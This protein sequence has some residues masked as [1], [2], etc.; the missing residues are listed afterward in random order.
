MSSFCL[1]LVAGAVHTLA[2]LNGHGTAGETAP[3]PISAA[4]IYQTEDSVILPMDAL[5]ATEKVAPEDIRRTLGY[6]EK[7]K[8]GEMKKRES[9][10]VVERGDETYSIIDGNRSYMALKQLGAKNVPAI[11]F[12][13]PFH[14]DVKTFDELI[15]LQTEAVSEFH[16]FVTSLGEAHR[17]EVSEHSDPGNAEAIHRKARE[18]YGEDYAKVVDILSADISLAA[19]ALQKAVAELFDR[20]SIM[21]VYAHEEDGGS[22]AYIRLS[23]GALAEI[24]LN[25][26]PCCHQGGA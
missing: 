18:N 10:S 2:F 23:N 11:V 19:E 13:R 25:E 6:I 24:R 4:D 12:S 1:L 26:A 3:D 14:K 20:D 5:R 15:A 16:Q 22:T 9:L 21:C 7:T 17:A 8:N